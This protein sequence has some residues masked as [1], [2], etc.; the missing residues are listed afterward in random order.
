M[1]EVRQ[2]VMRVS[3][4]TI[5]LLFEITDAILPER[6]NIVMTKFT[7]EMDQET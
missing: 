7:F 5:C 4:V 1:N 2:M 3:P 6:G